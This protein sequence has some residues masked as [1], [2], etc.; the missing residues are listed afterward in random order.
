MYAGPRDWG[1]FQVGLKAMS[2]ATEMAQ[3]LRALANLA[4]ELGLVP[5]AY[6]VVHNYL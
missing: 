6:V 2:G 5:N 3:W 1:P 4:E